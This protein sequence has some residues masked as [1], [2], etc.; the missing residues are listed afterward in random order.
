MFSF[1]V[2]GVIQID[3]IF[4]TNLKK[5]PRFSFICIISTAKLLSVL[6]LSKLQR[7]TSAS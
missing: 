6:F 4:F 7:N 1:P 2:T 5:S 3:V